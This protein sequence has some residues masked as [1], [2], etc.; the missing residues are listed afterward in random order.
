MNSVIREKFV[1]FSQRL[2]GTFFACMFWMV[3]GDF[4]L[5]TVQHWYVGI[6][7]AFISSTILL[8]L[9]LTEIQSLLT[10]FSRRLLFTSIVVAIV[11]HFVHPGHFGGEYT[12]AIATGLTAASLVALFGV[13]INAIQKR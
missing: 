4:R 9:S 2:L 1:F 12:E 10:S 11:D 13:I 6:K 8:L 7:T 5:V 3:Q